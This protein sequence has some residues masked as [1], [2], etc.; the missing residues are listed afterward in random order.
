MQHI[1]L[2]NDYRTADTYATIDD[3]GND[4]ASHLKTYAF[5]EGSDNTEPNREAPGGLQH[6]FVEGETVR[7]SGVAPGGA[8]C[9]AGGEAFVG[10]VLLRGD[11][12]GSVA[13]ANA[14]VQIAWPPAPLPPPPC[15]RPPPSLPGA[16][17][18]QGGTHNPSWRQ[19]LG[20]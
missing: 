17:A 7:L 16:W 8:A 5:I 1:T 11:V 18:P 10:R 9:A 14:A 13:K 3:I 15:A 6:D 20:A 4:P 12:A 2:T 19:L